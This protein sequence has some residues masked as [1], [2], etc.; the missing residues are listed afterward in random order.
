[1]PALR[2]LFLAFIFHAAGL[3]YFAEHTL[4]FA[5]PFLRHFI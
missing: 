2:C 1:M 5:T 3:R 4:I